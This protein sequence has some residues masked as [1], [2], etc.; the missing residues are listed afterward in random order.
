MDGGAF[1]LLP[2]APFCLDRASFPLPVGLVD[3]R[4]V[5]FRSVPFRS[6]PFRLAFR[7]SPRR[8]FVSRPVYATRVA[9]RETERS[10][11]G[12]GGGENGR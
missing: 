12:R 1:L 2:S 4:F 7:R 9:G 5:P 6:V 3:S 10:M 11:A 8:S